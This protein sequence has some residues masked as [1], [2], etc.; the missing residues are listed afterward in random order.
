MF[1]SLGLEYL[2]LDGC[3]YPFTCEF[4]SFV[5]I[6]EWIIF[7]YINVFYCNIHSL[8]DVE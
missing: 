8:V 6:N 2:T 4:H 3:F 5:F 7:F 1:V